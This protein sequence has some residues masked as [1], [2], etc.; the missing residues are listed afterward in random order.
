MLRRKT[1][2]FINPM[3]DLSQLGENLLVDFRTGQCSP[4][5]PPATEDAG[6]QTQTLLA[7]LLGHS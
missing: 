3:S 5:T 7:T 4:S 6:D 1:L 2:G